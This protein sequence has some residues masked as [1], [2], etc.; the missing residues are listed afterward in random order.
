MQVDND[1]EGTATKRSALTTYRVA[2]EMSY[3]FI[4]PLK[5]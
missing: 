1:S 4:I 5:V 2:H 3:H